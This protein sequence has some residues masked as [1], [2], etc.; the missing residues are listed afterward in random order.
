MVRGQGSSGA[1]PAQV[2]GRLAPL[3]ACANRSARPM[4]EAIEAKLT[5]APPRPSASIFFTPACRQWKTPFTL[6]W[7]NLPEAGTTVCAG[8]A[9]AVRV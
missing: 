4:S 7:Y 2:A 9:C 3:P 6:T 5:M 1:L 8:R